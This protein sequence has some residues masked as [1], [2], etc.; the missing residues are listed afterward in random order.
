MF[1]G[2]LLFTKDVNDYIFYK[3]HLDV[4]LFRGSAADEIET[5]VLRMRTDDGSA[6]AQAVKTAAGSSY[7]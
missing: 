4:A 2:F 5:S 1:A 6:C 3:A 7:R